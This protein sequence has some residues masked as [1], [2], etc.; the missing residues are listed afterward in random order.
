[1]HVTFLPA[2]L[3][4]IESQTQSSP[5][6][7]DSHFVCWHAH[8]ILRKLVMQVTHLTT[9]KWHFITHTLC[10]TERVYSIILCWYRCTPESLV[11]ASRGSQGGWYWHARS[12]QA[13]MVL[14]QRDHQWCRT[15]CWRHSL[16]T[17]LAFC[18][19]VYLAISLAKMPSHH[20]AQSCAQTFVVVGFELA[21]WTAFLWY[22]WE[23]KIPSSLLHL[24][25]MELLQQ[26]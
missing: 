26:Q 15:H 14:P 13:C 10:V 12:Y 6:G 16:D 5:F 22:L 17:D 19:A 21:M 11:W 4:Q 20:C 18:P 8:M 3:V 1:M 9:C 2:L 23:G 24:I 25:V 7:S